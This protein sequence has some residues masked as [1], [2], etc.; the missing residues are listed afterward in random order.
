M[1]ADLGDAQ[2]QERSRR[3]FLKAAGGARS[4]AVPTRPSGLGRGCLLPARKVTSIATSRPGCCTRTTVGHFSHG[5]ETRAPIWP[6]RWR[7]SG[8]LRPKGNEMGGNLV[9]LS[10]GAAFITG[11]VI[12]ASSLFGG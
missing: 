4:L 12:A 9:L 8:L 3:R 11:I 6:G 7:N 1:Y 10:C 5:T 2:L